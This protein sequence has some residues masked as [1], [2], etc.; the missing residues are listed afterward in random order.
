MET[1]HRERQSRAPRKP[2]PLKRRRNQPT[3]PRQA[4]SDVVYLPPQHFSRNRLIL[5]LATVA[6][7]V[8]ALL[9]GVSVFFKVQDHA[10]SGCDKY[11]AEQIWS[12]SGIREGENLLTIDIPKAAARIMQELPYVAT[13]RI[14]VELPNKVNIE[15][16]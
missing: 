8:L 9:L 13:V 15:V 3:K 6:A 7:V 12:A 2:A 16:V 5:Q 4:A 14:G 1:K 10:V 11:T